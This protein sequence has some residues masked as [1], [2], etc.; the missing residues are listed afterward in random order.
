MTEGQHGAGC[1][2]RTD[3]QD[4]EPSELPPDEQHDCDDGH[5]AAC[6]DLSDP[7]HR[8]FDAR[9]DAADRVDQ[10]GLRAADRV[11][12]DG[13]EDHAEHDQGETHEQAQ[14]VAGRADALRALDIDLDRVE[15]DALATREDL[16]QGRLRLRRDGYAFA[17]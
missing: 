12:R 8:L 13:C 1:D 16:T 5:E 9:R 17:G 4:Q 11:V 14:H 3:Q 6:D 10:V 15:I 7:D 2:A